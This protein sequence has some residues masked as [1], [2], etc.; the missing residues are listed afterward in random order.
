MVLKELNIVIKPIGITKNKNTLL[1]HLALRGFTKIKYIY[2]T[3]RGRYKN[4]MCKLNEE[5][6]NL[7][8]SIGGIYIGS[9][10]TFKI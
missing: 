6:R 7:L 8:N 5:H 2:I 4:M 10:G 9:K 3:K 1:N